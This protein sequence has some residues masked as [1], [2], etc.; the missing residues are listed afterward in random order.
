MDKLKKNK[1]RFIAAVLGV[2]I[3]YFFSIYWFSDV[4]PIGNMYKIIHVIIICILIEGSAC[5][6]EKYI[7][8]KSKAK[9]PILK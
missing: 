2:I 1:G 6:G 8:K 4:K 7:D 3:S 9:V 5:I